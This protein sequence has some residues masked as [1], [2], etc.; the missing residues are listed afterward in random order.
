MKNE[1]LLFAVVSIIGLVLS[2]ALSGVKLPSGYDVGTVLAWVA[3]IGAIGFVAQFF[4]GLDLSV[5]DE[6]IRRRKLDEDLTDEAYR[7]SPL[8]SDRLMNIHYDMFKDDH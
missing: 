4:D 2:Q 7:T 8:Y 5:S 6:E 1:K 3:G